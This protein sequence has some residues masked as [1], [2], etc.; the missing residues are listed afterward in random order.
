MILRL[1][2]WIVLI[3]GLIACSAEPPPKSSEEKASDLTRSL[4]KEMNEQDSLEA[5]KSDTL[6]T[7]SLR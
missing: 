7:D 3:T 5:L 6:E 1:I 2:I 4:L